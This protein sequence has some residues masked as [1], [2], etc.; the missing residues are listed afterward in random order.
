MMLDITFCA[1]EQCPVMDCIR[2]QLR[3][4]NLNATYSYSCA[5]KEAFPECPFNEKFQ[6]GLE[7]GDQDTL[8]PA[9]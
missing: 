7:Y 5:N 1:E 8:M 2:N 6:Q 9:T 3:I 4:R